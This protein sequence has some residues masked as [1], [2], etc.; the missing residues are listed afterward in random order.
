MGNFSKVRTLRPMTK[1]EIY[2]VVL[3]IQ[4]FILVVIFFVVRVV[5]NPPKNIIKSFIIVDGNLYARLSTG[6]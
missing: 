4:L 5:L 6:T 3:S 1:G 2:L